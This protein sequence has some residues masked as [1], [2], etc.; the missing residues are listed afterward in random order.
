M[1]YYRALYY[2]LFIYFLEGGTALHLAGKHKIVMQIFVFKITQHS[3]CVCGLF[4]CL[5]LAFF[6]VI[7]VRGKRQ[8]TN[9]ISS[10][11]LALTVLIKSHMLNSKK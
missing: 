1:D 3:I 10:T 4:L 6:I 5:Y 7:N 8:T 11:A 2:I 9:I